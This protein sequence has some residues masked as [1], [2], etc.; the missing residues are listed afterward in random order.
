MFVRQMYIKNFVT[1][2]QNFL[3]QIEKTPST[4]IFIFSKI[5]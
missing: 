5:T 1:R 3:A 4:T 2:L